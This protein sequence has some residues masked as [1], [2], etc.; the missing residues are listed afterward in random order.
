MVS[1]VL[2]LM[3]RL[4]VLVHVTQ[5][6]LV[7]EMEQKIMGVANLN[8]VV[9][10]IFYEDYKYHKLLLIL[11]YPHFR[12]LISLFCFQVQAKLQPQ[13]LLTPKPPPQMPQLQKLK[14]QVHCKYYYH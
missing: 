1:C 4:A 14:K 12:T 5:V 9:R 7:L 3:E 8:F 13:K 2:Q 10:K 11:D 6:N